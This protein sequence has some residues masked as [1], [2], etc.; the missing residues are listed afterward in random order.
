MRGQ[1]QPAQWEQPAPQLVTMQSLATLINVESNQF[2]RDL[3]ARMQNAEH[4]PTR[5]PT[6]CPRSATTS[7]ASRMTRMSS[8]ISLGSQRGSQVP[9]CKVGRQGRRVGE[10]ASERIVGGSGVIK[11]AQGHLG[12]ERLRAR[13][14]GRRPS[15]S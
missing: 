7:R 3:G 13:R 14:K 15:T 11:N 12:G 4:S 1:R 8:I 5:S 10:E 6:A 2:R 9:N